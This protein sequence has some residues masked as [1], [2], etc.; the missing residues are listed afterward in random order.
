MGPR[1]PFH[2]PPLSFFFSLVYF[3]MTFACLHILF[4]S[5]QTS[6]GK[7]INKAKPPASST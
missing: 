1:L 5:V 7:R 6:K 4:C 2:F 3:R